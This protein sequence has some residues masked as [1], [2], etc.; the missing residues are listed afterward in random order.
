[1]VQSRASFVAKRLAQLLLVVLGIAVINFFLLHLAPGDAAQVLA[2]EAGSATPEY[3]A[4]LRKQ[5]GLDQP[6]LVQFA[7]YLRNLLTLNLGF[8]FR[9]GLPVLDLILQRLPAT[10]LLLAAAIGFAVV[11]GCGLGIAAARRAGSL[12]DTLISAI[13]L[14]FYATPVFWTGLVLI[15]VFSVWLDWLPVGGMAAIESGHTGLAY[16]EDVASH[17][18]L[19]AAT[20]G[21]FYL[22]V[23]ARLMRAAMIEVQGQDFVR[24]ATAKGVRPSRI[25]W[26][27]VI[28]NALLPVVT[29]LGV[30]IGSVLGGAVLVETVFSWP[31]LGRLAF[32]ALFQ[33]DL[34]LLL[35]ILLCSSVVVVIANVATDLLYTVLDPRIE[36]S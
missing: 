29:M 35:G 10:L 34:N 6:L 19:P 36:L 20:L 12:F 7:A 28:R 2:G 25:A 31:G 16:V 27:H 26:R 23:Y 24:T 15:V 3:L 9:Q 11:A 21:S 17:L 22:A 14:L 33:R 5:F 30:Q 32:E 4:A 8:S 1:M 18:V 13:A